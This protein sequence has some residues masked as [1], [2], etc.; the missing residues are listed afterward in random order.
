MK[1]EKVI[2]IVGVVAVIAIVG[3]LLYKSSKHSHDTSGEE[4]H[5]YPSTEDVKRELNRIVKKFY[6]SFGALL[7]VASGQTDMAENVF[8]NLTLTIKHS[9]SLLIKDWWNNFIA[10]N[11]EWGADIYVSKAS[12]LL[13]MFKSIGVNQGGIEDVVINDSIRDKYAVMDELA[14]GEIG[15]VSMPYWEYNGNIVEKGILIK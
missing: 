4:E 15:K 5:D 2:I 13:E 6:D 9:D 12:E 8:E 1:S 11:A 10:N 14:D 3:A 7:N